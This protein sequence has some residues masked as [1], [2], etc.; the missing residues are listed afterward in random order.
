M[1]LT[2]DFTGCKVTCLLFFRA[3]RRLPG[4]R[5][6]ATCTRIM[7]TTYSTYCTF[8]SS[9]HAKHAFVSRRVTLITGR[10]TWI[11]SA[12]RKFKADIAEKKIRERGEMERFRGSKKGWWWGWTY[13]TEDVSDRSLNFKGSSSRGGKRHGA[14]S[15]SFFFFLWVYAGLWDT[16][17][18]TMKNNLAVFSWALCIREASRRSRRL[19]V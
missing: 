6:P 2:A 4:S 11:Y 13:Q 12:A 1:F 15:L 10:K 14:V 5:P 7:H 3:E 19:L 8:N 17:R 16:L 18:S 9:S